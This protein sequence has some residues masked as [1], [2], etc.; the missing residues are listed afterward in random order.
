MR[1][2]M[3]EGR[4]FEK[5][6][7]SLLGGAVG[8]ALGWPVE[9]HDIDEIMETYG[10]CGIVDF[11]D[12]YGGKGAVTDDTQ[13][14]LFTAEGLLSA[15]EDA[16]GDGSPTDYGAALCRAYL[17]WLRS[18]DEYGPEPGE[19]G[20]LMLPE[21]HVR[22]APGTTCL[23]AL[24]EICAGVAKTPVNESKG[25][26]GVMRVAPVGLFCASLHRGKAGSVIAAEAFDLGCT[27]AAITHGHPSGYLSAGTFAALIALIAN[28]APLDAA[29]RE[30]LTVLEGQSGS[31]E[32]V[33]ALRRALALVDTGGAAAGAETIEAIGGGWVGEE[34]LAISIYCAIKADGDFARGVRLAVNHSGDSDSTGSITGNILGALLGE[35]AIPKAWVEAVEL[36]ETVRAV[37]TSLFDLGGTCR[38]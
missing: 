3:S 36:R 21:L 16:A 32:C 19:T 7:G 26:G 34:A 11:V 18:Q 37:A 5:Y 23:S 38:E 25:C 27:A 28:G 6:T 33:M 12:A 2:M 35:G 10:C 13:M 24:K 30:S 8:D 9:F 15:L 31:R 29:V 4:S 17:R 22:R 20:L 14:T 1:V